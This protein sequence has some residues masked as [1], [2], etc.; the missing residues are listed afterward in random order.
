[1]DF[2]GTG[3]QSGHLI[4]RSTVK[5]AEAR[6]H[7]LDV[8][9][10]SKKWGGFNT[11][12]SLAEWWNDDWTWDDALSYFQ[13]NPS[14]FRKKMRKI[15]SFEWKFSVIKELQEYRCCKKSGIPPRSVFLMLKSGLN[16]HVCR[17]PFL[18]AINPCWLAKSPFFAGTVP[19]IS[20][21]T[22]IFCRSTHHFYWSN[23]HFVVTQ[24]HSNFLWVKTYP[25]PPCFCD[26]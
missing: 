24:T 17:F 16:Q 8:G 10:G 22:A 13:A 12:Q 11:P 9:S 6:I 20:R 5:A 15:N 14:F 1:M 4:V 26:F 21:V 18:W 23:H 7:V 2:Q 25:K 19:L 3:L